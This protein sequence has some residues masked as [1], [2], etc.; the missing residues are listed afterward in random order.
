MTGLVPA[1]DSVDAFIKDARPDKR[2]LLVSRLLERNDDYAQHWFTFWNDALRNDYSGTGYITG[3]RYDITRWLYNA[4]RDNKPYNSFVEE[5]ISPMSNQKVLLPA[6]NGGAP[7]MPVS[8]PKCRHTKCR[9]FS[10]GLTEMCLPAM[11]VL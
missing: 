9:R 5:L 4:L 10:S 11:I 8:V 7:L 1:A 3:G 6:S 2:E